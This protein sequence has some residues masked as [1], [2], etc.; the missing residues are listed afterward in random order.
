MVG[1]DASSCR[2]T[3]GNA[4]KK[5]I[6]NSSNY[7]KYLNPAIMVPELIPHVNNYKLSLTFCL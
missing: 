4:E 2:S 7:I 1:M 6:I 3:V 5:R